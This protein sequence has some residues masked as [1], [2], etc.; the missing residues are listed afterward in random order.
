MVTPTPGVLRHSA[1]HKV[2]QKIDSLLVLSR[3]LTGF[4]QRLENLE[5]CHGKDRNMTNLPNVMEFC[6]QSWNFTKFTKFDVF[7]SPLKK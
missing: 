1:L 4:P 5:N 3:S 6:D 2:I 7:M